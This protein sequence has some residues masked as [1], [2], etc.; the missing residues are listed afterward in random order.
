MRGIFNSKSPPKVYPCADFRCKFAP[1]N[2]QTSVQRQAHHPV[3]TLPH[4]IYCCYRHLHQ[5]SCS[6]GNFRIRC[7]LWTG[8]EEVSKLGIPKPQSSLV[9]K[10]ASCIAER[11]SV[12]LARPLSQL[13]N[14]IY[15][16]YG[17]MSPYYVAL[18]HLFKWSFMTSAKQDLST[19]DAQGIPNEAT[20]TTNKQTH[21]LEDH[22]ILFL[23]RCSELT[24]AIW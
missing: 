12:W 8:K 14:C 7:S 19:V 21:H 20:T 13:L 11:E 4:H 10:P 23:G 22:S 6:Q 18:P 16:N 2:L 3:C 9:W 17:H 1:T 24:L 15:A 5:L